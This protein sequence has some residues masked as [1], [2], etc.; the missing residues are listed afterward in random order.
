MEVL[1]A[2]LF[3]KDV[4]SDTGTVVKK[5][6]TGKEKGSIPSHNPFYLLEE[7]DEPDPKKECSISCGTNCYCGWRFR[8]Q[9]KQ[10]GHFLCPI[11]RIPTRY[12]KKEA[13]L[14]CHWCFIPL[15]LCGG[16]AV[17]YI[18]CYKCNMHFQPVVL[19]AQDTEAGKRIIISAMV[20]MLMVMEKDKVI[21]SPARKADIIRQVY[22]A[23]IQT[24]VA[25]D[26][27]A[28]IHKQEDAMTKGPSVN[29]FARDIKAFLRRNAP[30]LDEDEKKAVIAAMIR[31]IFLADKVRDLS[32]L[33]AQMLVAAGEGL[34]MPI[35]KI[36]AILASEY[37]EERQQHG[38]VDKKVEEPVASVA[39]EA[40]ET[41][42]V[43]LS[44]CDC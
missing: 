19:E 1:E 3:V 4:V 36:K 17:E 37:R 27:T 16:E 7:T 13:A 28:F 42:I 22:E 18:K 5:S 33:E 25:T 34:S 15:C 26:V 14:A 23:L 39:P 11:C 9:V 41:E 31:S 8:R 20:R 32:K 35:E 29:S 6:S 21:A 30:L 2:S 40:T 24:Q 10:T 38:A 43:D 44:F 12:K